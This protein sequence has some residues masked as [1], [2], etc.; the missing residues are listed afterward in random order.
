M[1]STSAAQP[2]GIGVVSEKALVALAEV[3][4]DLLDLRG[5]AI[6][7]SNRNCVQFGIRGFKNERTQAA[8][9]M[10]VNV[11]DHGDIHIVVRRGAAAR[12]NHGHGGRGDLSNTQVPRLK[13]YACTLDRLARQTNTNLVRAAETVEFSAA[14]PIVKLR[15]DMVAQEVSLLGLHILGSPQQ[16]ESMTNWLDPHFLQEVGRQLVQILHTDGVGLEILKVL[17]HIEFFEP[18][19][20][21][22]DLAPQTKLDVDRISF[23]RRSSRL[24]V[25]ISLHDCLC[26]LFGECPGQSKQV[27]EQPS[28]FG[29][30]L[31][32]G[33]QLQ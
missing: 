16:R 31:T 28:D 10:E 19:L 29:L 33:N 6:A 25:V 26:L 2:V 7:Q 21:R 18:A 30:P 15:H 14:S 27:D 12:I 22:R 32:Q 8:S 3:A 1:T 13:T 17:R 20:H 11:T 23:R 9:R 24:S 4:D 5:S